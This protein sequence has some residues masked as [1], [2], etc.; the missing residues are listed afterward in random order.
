MKRKDYE[1]TEDHIQKT[2]EQM[3]IDAIK[4]EADAIPQGGSKEIDNITAQQKALLDKKEKVHKYEHYIRRSIIWFR[5]FDSEIHNKLG[6][7][8][9]RLKEIRAHA[10]QITD[11]EMAELENW[12][13]KINKIREHLKSKQDAGFAD[14][15]LANELRR[16]ISTEFHIPKFWQTLRSFPPKKIP[17]KK[18]R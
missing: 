17:L 8:S 7:T 11:D 18:N 6:V 10:E 4:K 12:I 3:K 1:G 9:D 15:Q 13:S 2:L 16:C 14:R 5:K